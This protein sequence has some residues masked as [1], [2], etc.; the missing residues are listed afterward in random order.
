MDAFEVL[1][2]GPFTSI[3]DGGRYGYQQFGIPVSGALDTFAY[4]AANILVG[5]Q[6]NEAVLEIT[7]AGPRL[8]VLANATVAVTGAEIPILVNDRPQPLWTSFCVCV[9]DVIV[10]RTAQK[11]VRAY[12]AVRG[13]LDVPEIMG[14]R[15]TYPGG[16]IGGLNGRSLARGDRLSRGAVEA[17]NRI[18]FLPE[19]FRPQLDSKITLRAIP[20]PQ[21]DYFGQGLQVFFRSEFTVASKADRMGYR[22]EGAKIDMK[23]GVPRSII[24][25]PSLSGAVQVPPDGQPIILLVEQTVGGYAKIATII[26]PDL[27]LVAQAKPGDKVRFASTELSEAHQIYCDYRSRLDR[28][29]EC[30]RS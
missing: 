30:I 7:F 25:E 8:K 12:L 26:S 18:I 13:G 21:D 22:L 24:S 5:N 1:E 14:S 28:M 3:Q 27:D 23:E 20:G 9:G 11:G 17:L 4:R 2:P 6:G 29:R 15:S 16:K 10:M 19:R